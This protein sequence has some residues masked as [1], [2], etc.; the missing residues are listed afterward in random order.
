M[1]QGRTTRLSSKMRV[2]LGITTEKSTNMMTTPMID[3]AAG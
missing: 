2:I 1:V 3:M